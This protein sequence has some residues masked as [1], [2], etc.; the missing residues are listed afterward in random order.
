VSQVIGASNAIDHS[1]KAD[2]NRL[3]HELSAVLEKTPT[4][5]KEAAEALAVSVDELMTKATKGKPNRTLVETAMKTAHDFAKSITGAAPIVTQ[6]VT[7]IGKLF[8]CS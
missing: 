6:I 3:V 5:Q 7:M 8:G 4:E 2:L 1:A